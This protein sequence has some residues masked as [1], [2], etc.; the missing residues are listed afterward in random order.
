MAKRPLI[1][2]VICAHLVRIGPCCSPALHALLCTCYVHFSGCEG[3]GGIF[4]YTYVCCYP[5]TRSTD[6]NVLYLMEFEM[7]A[8]VDPH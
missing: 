7:H 5:R 2:V 8:V 6:R 3:G 1:D 4:N